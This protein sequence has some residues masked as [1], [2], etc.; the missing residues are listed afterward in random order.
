VAPS[1]RDIDRAGIHLN[2]LHELLADAE[3]TIDQVRSYPL[4]GW[5]VSRVAR[6]CGWTALGVPPGNGGGLTYRIWRRRCSRLDS[7]TYSG[8]GS[9]C[10]CGVRYHWFA[11]LWIRFSWVRCTIRLTD[12]TMKTVI[13]VQRRSE[14]M[15]SSPKGAVGSGLV[16]RPSRSR[17]FRRFLLLFVFGPYGMVVGPARRADDLTTD[18]KRSGFGAVCAPQARRWCAPL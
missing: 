16:T 10:W 17:P 14:I 4:E 2:L 1:Q 8:L 7:R 3:H 9:H 18:V 11:R 13:P 5:T 12:Q 6:A 15:T